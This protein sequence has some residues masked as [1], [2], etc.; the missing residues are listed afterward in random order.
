MN[1]VLRFSNW[2]VQDW[3]AKGELEL[4]P[5]IFSQMSVKGLWAYAH[6]QAA[7]Y[8]ALAQNCLALWRV[9][10]AHVTRMQAIILNPSLAKPDEFYGRL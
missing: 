1:C 8:Q 9:I 3:L 2:K 4:W 7:L 5:G 10:P 6:R